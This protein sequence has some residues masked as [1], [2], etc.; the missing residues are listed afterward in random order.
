[1]RGLTQAARR[2]LRASSSLTAR[3]KPSS[4]AT[5]ASVSVPGVRRAA[6]QRSPG[7]AAR[8]GP[9]GKGF[10]W[11]CHWA[12]PSFAH[13]PLRPADAPCRCTSLRQVRG[14]D[15]GPAA[16]GASLAGASWRSPHVHWRF[17][18]PSFSGGFAS[19]TSP[20]TRSQGTYDTAEEAARV[21]DAAAR[22]LRGSA[23]VCNY[24]EG[25][26]RQPTLCAPPKTLTH[27]HQPPPAETA[28]GFPDCLLQQ[29]PHLAATNKRG[30]RAASAVETQVRPQQAVRTPVRR[31]RAPTAAAPDAHAS[32]RHFRLL[33]R[34]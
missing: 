8:A 31:A 18:Q 30:K 17:A 3:S 4:P 13:G 20:P 2:L 1:M 12:Q 22:H 28:K 29:M 33:S 32:H 27:H 9:V 19:L 15:P 24:P 16:L 25:A 11:A 23:A 6:Q 7:R 21:Y 34:P 5:E 14:R 10:A 26:Q